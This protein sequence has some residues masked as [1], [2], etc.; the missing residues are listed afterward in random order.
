ME[1]LGSLVESYE[2]QNIPQIKGDPIQTLQSL[3]KEHNL[4]QLDLAEIGI[5]GVVSEILSGKGN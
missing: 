1:T 2:V 3:M 4:K 5:Q